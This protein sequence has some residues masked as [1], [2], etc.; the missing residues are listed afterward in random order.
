LVAG[1][2]VLAGLIVGAVVLLVRGQPSNEPQEK[3]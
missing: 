1:G 3:E 2:I